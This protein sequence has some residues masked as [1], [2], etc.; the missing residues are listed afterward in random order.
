MK[1]NVF[2]EPDFDTTYE[3]QFDGDLGSIMSIDAHGF[4]DFADQEL[5]VAGVLEEELCYADVPYLEVEQLWRTE[6]PAD[7]FEDASRWE[8]AYSKAE[9]CG[10]LAV[11]R[12]QVAS[13]WSHLCVNHPD[14]LATQGFPASNIVEDQQH[15][16]ENGY[17]YLCKPCAKRFSDRLHA[18]QA[19]AMKER[20]V[21]PYS[22]SADT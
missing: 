21:D 7:D 5:F 18:A 9:T 17:V 13:Y 8:Y 20:T 1:E 2:H 10:A 11:T 12:F 19:A 15:L 6:H 4:L 3:L 14:E 16:A 22:R